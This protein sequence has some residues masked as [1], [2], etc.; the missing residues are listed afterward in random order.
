MIW[1]WSSWKNKVY[2][3]GCNAKQGRNDQVAEKRK[4]TVGRIRGERFE[5]SAFSFI[6]ISLGDVYSHI[7]KKSSTEYFFPW[8]T[9]QCFITSYPHSWH[10]FVLFFWKCNCILVAQLLFWVLIFKPFKTYFLLPLWLAPFKVAQVLS[11]RKGKIWKS[12]SVIQSA[13]LL[14]SACRSWTGLK[15]ILKSLPSRV[16]WL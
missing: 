11:H 5:E 8:R 15:W 9:N 13:L 1:G 7:F 16:W 6:R 4:H 2:R 3:Q 14:Y 10:L 12:V